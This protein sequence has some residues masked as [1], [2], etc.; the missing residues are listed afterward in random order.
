MLLRNQRHVWLNKKKCNL[1]TNFTKYHLSLAISVVLP[2]IVQSS[3]INRCHWV[4]VINCLSKKV[5][6]DNRNS[7]DE[8]IDRFSHFFPHNFETG[9]GVPQKSQRYAAGISVSKDS[10]GSSCFVKMAR[11][12]L[13][14]CRL[15]WRNRL[16]AILNELEI[17]SLRFYVWVM[18]L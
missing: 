2:F 1:S 6:I 10:L 18:V 4:L 11:E 8:G 9:H 13:S 12:C 7:Y 16:M 14:L 17:Q 3:L 5:Y 15:C